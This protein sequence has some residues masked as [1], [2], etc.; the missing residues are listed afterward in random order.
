MG[1]IYFLFFFK[2]LLNRKRKL[3]G[4]FFIKH[5]IRN[6][7]I[8]LITVMLWL[9]FIPVIYVF[10]LLSFVKTM[11]FFIL[12]IDMPLLFRTYDAFGWFNPRSLVCGAYLSHLYPYQISWFPYAEYD[13]HPKCSILWCFCNWRLSSWP[14]TNK[15]IYSCLSNHFSFLESILKLVQNCDHIC[16]PNCNR[17][18]KPNNP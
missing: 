17:F 18:G 13:I 4:F 8:V 3:R 10:S 11:P 5:M 6:H 1:N 16:F 15:L 12:H 9:W 14:R 2:I 7:I